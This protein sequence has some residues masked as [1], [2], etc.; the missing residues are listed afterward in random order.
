LIVFSKYVVVLKISQFQ[1]LFPELL[2]VIDNPVPT[3]SPK[4]PLQSNNHGFMFSN[5]IEKQIIVAEN[6]QNLRREIRFVE[7]LVTRWAFVRGISPDTDVPTHGA[8]PSMYCTGLSGR[9]FRIFS[10][11]TDPPL[12]FLEP[13][14]AD[15]VHV[16]TKYPETGP[17]HYI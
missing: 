2:K 14:I 13:Q 6:L 15:K 7:H 12:L 3:V 9:A 8:L 5:V 16:A 11:L 4:K 17:Y 1:C 10:Q